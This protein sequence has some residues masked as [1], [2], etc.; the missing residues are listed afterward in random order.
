ME[1]IMKKF[2]I[3]AAFAL[4]FSV[5]CSNSSSKPVE[6]TDSDPLVEDTDQNPIDDD[7]ETPDDDSNTLPDEDTTEE[8]Q[9]PPTH[10][11]S[12]IHI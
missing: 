2:L 5:S 6:I 3:F 8:Q 10:K 4:I 7:I 9:V 11:L 12:L 1:I